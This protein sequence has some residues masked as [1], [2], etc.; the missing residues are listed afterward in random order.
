MAVAVVI[1]TAFSRI[2][3]SLVDHIIMPLLSL[4]T[5]NINYT[6]L[7]VVFKPAS[8]T[9]AE[10]ALRYGNFIQLIIEFIIISISVFII[11]SILMRIKNNKDEVAPDKKPEV[12]LL[13]E[14]RD[15]IKTN[16]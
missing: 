14:I 4:V 6:D 11:Y 12:I 13:E 8:E 1:G 7:K 2:V 3:Q 9:S 5:G 10:V 15:I 16:H